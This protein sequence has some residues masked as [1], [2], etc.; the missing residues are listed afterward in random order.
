M[1]LIHLADVHL[2]SKMQSRLTSDKAA[3]RRREIRASFLRTVEFAECNGVTA[4]IIAGDLFD[5]NTPLKKDKDFFYD[6]VEKHGGVDFL[7]LRGNHDD[8]GGYDRELPNLKTFDK[9]WKSYRYGEVVVSGVEL[10]DENAVSLYSSLNLNGEDFNVAVMH[11]EWGSVCGKQNV[12]LSKLKGKNVDY[13]A[14][15]HIHYA[16]EKSIDE[17]GI[18]RYSGCL[19]GRGFD[20]TGKK[21]F[22]LLDIENGRMKSEFV[23]VASRQIAKYVVDVDGAKGVGEAY[24]RVKAAIDCSEDDL[25]RVELVGERQFDEENLAEDVSGYLEDKYFFVSVKDYSV[26]KYEASDY[27]GDLTLRGEFVRRVLSDDSLPSESKQK[28]IAYGLKALSG[29]EIDL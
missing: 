18:A 10:C 29:R 1:K 23:S 21:G 2:G 24:E 13:L 26:R 22:Y 3:L 19:E 5:G 8:E 11:G 15:G 14:L 20:D 9:E 12:N 7:Y 16:S 4:I 28:I 25:V 17:R 6:V 27:E